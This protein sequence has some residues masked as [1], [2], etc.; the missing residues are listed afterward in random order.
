M[1]G[2]PKK[3]GQKL[4]ERREENTL[5]E[6]KLLSSKTDFVSNDYLGMAREETVF[7]G[8]TGI[9]E[10]M[11]MLRNGSTG[12][13]LLSGNS[14]LHE[15]TEAV[16]AG[17]YGAES[18][19]IFNSGYDANLGL[20][21][22]VPQRDDVVLYD[23]YIHA[24][25]RDG[26]RMGLAKSYKYRHNDLDHLR[27]LLLRLRKEGDK[28]SQFYL[29]TEAVFS[30]DGDQ[31]DL[32]SLI[33]LCD[34]FRCRLILDEAH[35]ILGI[36]RTLGDLADQ[37]TVR[38]VVFARIATFGK[39]MGVQGAA[40]LGSPQ[41]RSYLVN[42]A[43]SFIYST[44]LPPM[45]VAAV[46]F[47]CEQIN[48]EE[49]L[50]KK[51]RLRSN[52]EMFLKIRDDLGLRERFIP[53]RSAI[54]SCVIPGNSGVKRV[55]EDLNRKGYNVLPILSPTVPSGQE[56]IR[57]CLHSFNSRDEIKEVLSI[58]ARAIEENVHA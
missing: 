55:S 4:Q 6:L 20:F 13:R 56:R 10:S 43:R 32:D 52:I 15:K 5:R 21:S 29:A 24:S 49:Y 26:I 3:L 27:E 14:P 11:G 2:F 35:A 25:M 22:C 34:E 16:L 36:D 51:E 17:L 18:A 19:L 37:E 28:D 30:M 8:A 9:L 46:L 53:S 38:R 44:A 1:D 7:R 48:K 39:A 58:L 45:S 40:V 33:K 41:L 31:P 50:R 57:F 42:F 54:H 12:S 47:A 23:E